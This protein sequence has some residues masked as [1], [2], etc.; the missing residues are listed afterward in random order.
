MEN[1]R[2]RERLYREFDELQSKPDINNCYTVDYWD[3]DNNYPDIFHWQVILIPPKGTDYEG[4]LFKL[5]V[6]FSEDYPTTPPQV[7][8]LTRIYH[9][10]IKEYDGKICLNALHGRYWKPTYTMEN[11]LDYII[12]LLYKQNP[13][14]PVNYEAGQ[15]YK[16]DRNKFNENLKKYLKEYANPNDFDNLLKQK[17]NTL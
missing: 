13:D 1:L 3:P 11:I 7:I 10:N 4:G 15:L 16:K 14:S 6:K 12:I 9:C 8:F 5:E 2:G 17:I